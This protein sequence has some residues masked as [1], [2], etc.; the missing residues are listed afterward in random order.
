M[1]LE[2]FS[3]FKWLNEGEHI[4]TEDKLTIMAP[5]KS[6][7]F[8]DNEMSSESDELPQTLSNAPYYYTEVEGDFVMSVRVALTFKDTYDASSIM[9]HQ[10]E[11]C[12]AKA[13]FEKT[14][15]NTRAVVSVV[16]NQMTD[17]ANGNNIEGDTVWLQVA[18]VGQSF[19]FHYSLDGK[20]YEM[21]RYF[22]LPVTETIKVGLVA[23]APTGE[24]GERYFSDFKL[25]KKTVGNI[26]LGQ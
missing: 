15:F 8:N 13:C 10:H 6:D 16:R 4:L 20:S 7:F 26:R 12:W 23:Q 2:K 24:G 18:R 22:S 1:N 9:I 14:D 3:L 21:M 25:E 5:P 11:D 17:D 19:S